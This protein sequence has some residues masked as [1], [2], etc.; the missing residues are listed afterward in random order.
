MI[1]GNIDLNESS[2]AVWRHLPWILLF[3]VHFSNY[4]IPEIKPVDDEFNKLNVLQE[5]SFFQS[6]N[7]NKLT[8]TVFLD[9][10]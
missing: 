9:P 8:L 2:T 1:E 7:K 10:G 6:L 4:S 5:Q 3:A